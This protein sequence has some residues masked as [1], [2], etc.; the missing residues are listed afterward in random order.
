MSMHDGARCMGS[1]Q[2]RLMQVTTFGKKGAMLLKRVE[3]ATGEEPEATL[4][5]VLQDLRQQL[6]HMPEPAAGRDEPGSMS[7]GDI[8]IFPGNVVK[9]EPVVLTLDR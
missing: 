5:S 2:V 6:D 9:S 8:P 1:E 3:T 4:E 7:A